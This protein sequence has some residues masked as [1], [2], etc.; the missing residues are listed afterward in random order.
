MMITAEKDAVIIM[1][2]ALDKF[3]IPVPLMILK[4]ANATTTTIRS[5]KNF[6]IG[7]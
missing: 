2:I 6:P 3:L 1:E 4:K 5:K 7:Y